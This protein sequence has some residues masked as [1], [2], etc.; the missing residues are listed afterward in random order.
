MSD[1]FTVKRPRLPVIDIARGNR[2][3]AFARPAAELAPARPVALAERLGAYY[4]RF[5]VV[6]RPGVFAGIAQAMSTHNVSMESIL[7]RARMPGEPVPV[8]MTT[9][10]TREADIMGA[11]EAIAALDAVVVA[12]RIIRIE[13]L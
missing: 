1:T 12:P 5:E 3:A 11:A 9:H 6:D 8:V 2:V 13:T 10:D 4:L 7:Q